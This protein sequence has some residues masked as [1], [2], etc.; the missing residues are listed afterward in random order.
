MTVVVS[1]VYTCT[2]TCTCVMACA[3]L[4]ASHHV[5]E[6]GGAVYNAVLG[7]VDIVRG[8]N[9]YYKLQLLAGDSARSY[10]IFRSWGRVGTSIGGT[11]VE[12]RMALS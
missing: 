1:G 11:K 4:E 8:T 10:Y 5:L 9:S 7:L 12:V 6:E 2:C 3:E